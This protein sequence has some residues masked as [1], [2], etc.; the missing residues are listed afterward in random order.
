MAKGTTMGRHQENSGRRWEARLDALHTRD[1][2]ALPLKSTL[3]FQ[4]ERYKS[5]TLAISTNLGHSRRHAK[6]LRPRLGAKK[7]SESTPDTGID[8]QGQQGQKTLA[9]VF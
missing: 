3:I 7:G 1:S 5:V 6:A 8:Q 4:R 2:T 9:G